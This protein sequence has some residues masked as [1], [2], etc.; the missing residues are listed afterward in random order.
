[1][2][3]TKHPAN[4]KPVDPV[5]PEGM[6]IRFNLTDEDLSNQQVRNLFDYKLGL[7]RKVRELRQGNA[8]Y[9]DERLTD[10]TERFGLRQTQLG[11]LARLIKSVIDSESYIAALTDAPQ[12]RN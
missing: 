6:K 1:M 4:L 10:L 2:K 3:P 5:S 12:E 8:L 9:S 7:D 11:R